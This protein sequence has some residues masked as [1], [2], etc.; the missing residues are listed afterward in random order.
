MTE[1]RVIHAMNA[2]LDSLSDGDWRNCQQAY[3]LRPQT[4]IDLKTALYTTLITL[5]FNSSGQ[6]RFRRA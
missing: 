2:S 3:A 4:A 6:R 5:H 1:W